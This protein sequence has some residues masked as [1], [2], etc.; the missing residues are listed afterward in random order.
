VGS[1]KKGRVGK[2]EKGHSLERTSSLLMKEKAPSEGV[3]PT[4]CASGVGREKRTS[5]KFG[6]RVAERGGG[7][8]RKHF[9]IRA[10]VLFPAGHARKEKKRLTIGLRR[11]GEKKNGL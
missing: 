10:P 11:L 6:L 7:K 8:E 9:H 5:A 4:S 2:E 1:K 3:S